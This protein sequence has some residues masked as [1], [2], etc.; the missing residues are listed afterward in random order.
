M[1]EPKRDPGIVVKPGARPEYARGKKWPAWAIL[2]IPFI[3]AMLVLYRLVKHRVRWIACSLT[4]LVF[5]AVMIVAEHNSIMRGH[6]VY[7]ENRILGPRIWEIPIE[8]PFMYYLL[9]PILAIMLFELVRG[10]LAGAI[11]PDW[12]GWLARRIRPPVLYG[13]TRA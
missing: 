11:K 5:E 6:W 9:P 1:P 8:E 12:R 13:R 7:N 3:I 10:L 2:A 4:V